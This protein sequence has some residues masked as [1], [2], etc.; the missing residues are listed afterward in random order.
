[1]LISGK[2]LSH[3]CK[4]F[5]DPNGEKS[6]LEIK[7]TSLNEEITIKKNVGMMHQYYRMNDSRNTFV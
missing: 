3:N 4:L 7:Y 6:F 5:R 1:M 2:S